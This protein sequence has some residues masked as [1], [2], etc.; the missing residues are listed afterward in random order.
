MPWR[1]MVASTASTIS[2]QSGFTSLRNSRNGAHPPNARKMPFIF[3]SAMTA[4]RAG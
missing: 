2:L 3:R 1:L 4:S